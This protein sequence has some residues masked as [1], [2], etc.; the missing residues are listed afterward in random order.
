MNYR[1][2]WNRKAL[3][4]LKDLD[5]PLR[6]HIF[7]KIEDYVSKDPTNIGKPLSNNLSGFW[8]YRFGDYRVIYTVDLKNMTMTV[9]VARHRKDVYRQS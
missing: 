3:D 9:L 6:K 7:E 5:K 2:L 1:V 4:S 8:C